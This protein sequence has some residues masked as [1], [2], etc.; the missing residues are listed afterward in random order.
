MGTMSTG[1]LFVIVLALICAN[2]P[3]VNQ[4]VLAV[5]PVR[6]PR[7]PFW[8]RGIELTVMYAVVGLVGF[9][10]E[11]GQGNAF[12]QGWQFYAIT[13]CLMLVFAFPGFTWQYLVRHQRR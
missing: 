3:F 11:S 5:L 4:R 8:L 2:L 7:K 13:A 9:G 1:S 10:I 6:W 12:P